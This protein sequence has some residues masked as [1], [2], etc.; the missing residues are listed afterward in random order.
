MAGDH[1]PPQLLKFILPLIFCS[2]SSAIIFLAFG[3]CTSTQVFS[4]QETLGVVSFFN[5]LLL[6]SLS[7]QTSLFEQVVC[8]DSLQFPILL[9]NTSTRCQ[10][11]ST[12]LLPYIAP[13]QVTRSSPP[14]CSAHVL[15]P[16]L[17]HASS[18]L[19]TPSPGNFL[20]RT[21]SLLFSSHPHGILFL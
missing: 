4:A 8:T 10:P 20:F 21:T 11:S 14:G 7:P 3:Y 17:Y 16:L 1:T 15:Q 19:A 12:L 18:L 9:C 2:F 5:F 13:A 6:V